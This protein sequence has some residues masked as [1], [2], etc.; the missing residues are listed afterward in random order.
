MEAQTDLSM[1][2][3]FL[4][5]D[6]VVKSVMLALIGAS[7]WSWAIVFEKVRLLSALNRLAKRFEEKFWSGEPLDDLYESVGRSAKDPM[8][9]VFVAAMRE[10]QRSIDRTRTEAATLRTS[11]TQRIERVM[12]IT[13]EKELEKVEARMS[14]L[15]STGSVAP[16]VGLFGTVWGIMNSFHAIGLSKNT[17][18]AVVAPGI[19]EALFATALGLVAAIPAVIAYNKLSSDIDRYAKRLDIFSSEFSAIV[20]RQLD[21]RR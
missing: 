6:W 3:L 5:A 1:I 12:Q 4:Q 10:W 17:S 8:S 14:F 13:S 15:A 21:E 7:I 2:A 20:S 11:L 9:A 16:F 18:L 19:A